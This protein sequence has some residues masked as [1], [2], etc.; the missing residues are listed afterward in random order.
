MKK[1][2]SVL[3]AMLLVFGIGICAYA[4]G[5]E[6]SV[7]FVNWIKDE[8]GVEDDEIEFNSETL[9]KFLDGLETKLAL[10]RIEPF[11]K[12]FAQQGYAKGESNIARANAQFEYGQVQRGNYLIVQH[13]KH[14]F[15]AYG[16][17][18]LAEANILMVTD[19]DDFVKNINDIVYDY[20]N[21]TDEIEMTAGLLGLSVSD[22]Q[23]YLTTPVNEQLLFWFTNYAKKNE[24]AAWKAL[25]EL[26]KSSNRQLETLI[27][28]HTSY[29]IEVKV[30]GSL[31][32]RLFAAESVVS[33][34]VDV[35][36]TMFPANRYSKLVSRVNQFYIVPRFYQTDSQLYNASNSYVKQYQRFNKGAY[37]DLF[38][39]A[40]APLTFGEWLMIIFLFGWIWM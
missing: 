3:L 37:K 36:E 31:F 1:L 26:M 33:R 10:P 22:Y 18:L 23:K 9:T 17:R 15:A 19:Y 38:S 2:L 35:S 13:M 27:H 5:K 16:A 24:R 11:G 7:L 4:G 20:N 29:N 39:E 32:Y 8:L 6:D 40:I 25:T 12:E 21:A 14:L 28:K 34:F 30:A